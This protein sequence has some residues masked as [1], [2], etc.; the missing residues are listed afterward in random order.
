MRFIPIL[1]VRDHFGATFRTVFL[2]AY[3]SS[4]V[5]LF[6]VSGVVEILREDLLLDFIL[7]ETH[8]IQRVVS[9][10]MRLVGSLLLLNLCLLLEQ[11]FV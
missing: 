7:L 8:W 11:L 1:R 2:L 5:Q 4:K 10:D 3:F 9:I 6:K